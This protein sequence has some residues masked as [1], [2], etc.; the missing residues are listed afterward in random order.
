MSLNHT[1]WYVAGSWTSLALLA[2]MAAGTWSGQSVPLL[3][4]IGLLPPIVM[5]ALWKDPSLTVAEVIRAA[6]E[7]R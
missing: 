4:V 6:E 7:R 1:R 2:F 5:L 3:G